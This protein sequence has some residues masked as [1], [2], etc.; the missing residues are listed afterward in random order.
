MLGS[1]TSIEFLLAAAVFVLSCHEFIALR[2]ARAEGKTEN[3]SRLIANLLIM[4]AVVIYGG[5]A[6]WTLPLEGEGP[7]R[8][9]DTPLVP[10]SFLILGGVMTV[11]AVYEG[12]ALVRARQQGLTRNVSRLASYSAM[13][14][15]VLAMLGLAERKWENYVDRLE[16]TAFEA[17]LDR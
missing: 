8:Q 5:V 2:R 9:L 1:Y 12:V 7:L 13:F 4:A 17:D 3:V 16:D 11:I 14:L 10:W 6:W 15:I